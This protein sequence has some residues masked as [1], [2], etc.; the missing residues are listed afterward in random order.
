MKTLFENLVKGTKNYIKDNHLETMVLGISGGIDSTV[1]AAICYEVS[2][3][4]PD[5]SFIG[6]SLPSLTNQGDENKAAKQVGE[7]FCDRFWTKYIDEEYDLLKKTFSINDLN[8]TSI[9]NGNIKARLRMIYLY[10]I[11]S[12]T[13]GIVM[14]T[15]NL[16]E[17]FLGFWTLHGD[18]GDFNPIGSLW[19][20]E[21][22]S[23]AEYLKDYWSNEYIKAKSD[24][25][26]DVE[27]TDKRFNRYEALRD[28]IPLTPTDG[29]G[30]KFGGDMAQIAPGMTYYGVNKV[31]KLL[32]KYENQSLGN[33]SFSDLVKIFRSDH[34]NLIGDFGDETVVGIIRRFVSSRF[35]RKHRPLILSKDGEVR[36]K[37][38]G[39]I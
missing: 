39:I 3:E 18:E 2:K 29:N 17:H 12:I 10:N 26:I 24:P 9:A 16:S 34:Q 33:L 15:D 38:A 8:Q 11:A 25:E 21:I 5:V 31:L 22:Y 30:V 27:A 7:A 1:V 35:K 14:D 13:K 4:L 6:V 32:A 37:K 19:I 20:D 23:L 28:S 36:E